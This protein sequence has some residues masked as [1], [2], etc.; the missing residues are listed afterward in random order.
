MDSCELNPCQLTTLVTAL[1]NTLAQNLTDDQLEVFSAMTVQ[2]GDTLGTI[3]A[4]RSICCDN[5]TSPPT[6]DL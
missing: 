4:Q 6:L 2:L 1:A 5:N 3:S